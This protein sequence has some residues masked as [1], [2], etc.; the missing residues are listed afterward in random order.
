MVYVNTQDKIGHF[1]PGENRD[2][3]TE[4]AWKFTI[5]TCSKLTTSLEGDDAGAAAA[6]ETPVARQRREEGREHIPEHLAPPRHVAACGGRGRWRRHAG[7]T[8]SEVRSRPMQRR[9]RCAASGRRKIWR[10]WPFYISPTS[11]CS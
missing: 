1:L 2:G 6:E 4:R 9:N 11:A 3:I 10:Q 8:S 7:D 5:P